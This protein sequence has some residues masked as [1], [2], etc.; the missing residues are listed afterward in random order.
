MQWL[1]HKSSGVLCSLFLAPDHGEVG[2]R[3]VVVRRVDHSQDP[4]FAVLLVIIVAV[5]LVLI[6]LHLL[7]L[8]LLGW[9]QVGHQSVAA[10]GSLGV[11]YS[12]SFGGILDGRSERP[13]P[14][15]LEVHGLGFTRVYDNLTLLLL[16]Q[17]GLDVLDQL[18]LG[19]E[20]LDNVSLSV[21]Q[22]QVSAGLVVERVSGQANW[23]LLVE[24]RLH[25]VLQG[26]HLVLQGLHL[27]LQLVVGL[28]L[29][30]QLVMLMHL[31][32]LLQLVVLLHLVVRH[33]LH[34]LLL[35]QRSHVQHV[36]VVLRLVVVVHHAGIAE[37]VLR[38]RHRSSG[39]VV[40]LLVVEMLHLLVVVVLK[41]TT[42]QP[43]V[44]GRRAGHFFPNSF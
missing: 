14:L 22:H 9:V 6:L 31:L 38:Q 29:V 28:H 43:L 32:V 34:L 20:S 4:H 11:R 13:R 44:G 3:R 8:V 36:P 40:H 33:L 24:R 42:C 23:V 1:L 12:L 26:L 15:A 25:L 18:L 2:L 10:L 19:I 35:V 17:H 39:V 7:L 37:V 30:L 16:V 41:V 27:V 21:S 5:E